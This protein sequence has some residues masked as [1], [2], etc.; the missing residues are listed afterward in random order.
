[1]FRGGEGTLLAGSLD[2]LN[3][4]S[5]EVKSAE[6]LLAKGEGP[7]GIREFEENVVGQAPL[8]VLVESALGICGG[9]AAVPFE[10]RGICVPI[11]DPSSASCVFSIKPTT[12]RYPLTDEAEALGLGSFVFGFGGCLAICDDGGMVRG[13]YTYAVP[14]GWETS[15]PYPRFTRFECWR[16]TL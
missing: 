15:E 2:E 14:S 16:V 6:L 13:E 3:S 1:V 10:D 7:W 8:V 9:F 4:I 12:A 5:I 11:A